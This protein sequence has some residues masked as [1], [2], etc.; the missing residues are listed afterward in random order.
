MN[1]EIAY[2]RQA[3]KK[4]TFS[5]RALLHQFLKLGMI[6]G[7]GGG[8][9]STECHSSYWMCTQTA[10]TDICYGASVCMC[11]YVTSNS[12]RKINTKV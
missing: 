10:A 2:I 8:M 4:H 5:N 9:R 11:A 12:T 6:S 1:H 7:L 3:Y